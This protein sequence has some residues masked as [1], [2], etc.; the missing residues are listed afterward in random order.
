MLLESRV[1]NIGVGTRVLSPLNKNILLVCCYVLVVPV[2]VGFLDDF[3]ENFML[4][5]L[6]M[7]CPCSGLSLFGTVPVRGTAY[8]AGVW[9][10]EFVCWFFGDDFV[11]EFL[12]N[13]CK[14]IGAVQG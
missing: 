1:R 10:V 6:M 5:L 12:D 8:A 2:F 3:F 13:C 9:F 14:M 7:L 11:L 4:I